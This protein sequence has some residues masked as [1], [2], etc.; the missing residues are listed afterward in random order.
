VYHSNVP[1]HDTEDCFNLKNEIE[2]LIK[3]EAIQCTLTPPNVNRNPVP[4]HQNQGDNMI[5]I[6]QEYDL[7]GTI[8]TIGNAEAAR[9]PPQKSPI[10]TIQLRPIV[11][12]QTFP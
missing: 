6:D 8:I 4:N 3:S 7:K 10:I 12:I 11:T 2:T 9:I 5:T 1:G